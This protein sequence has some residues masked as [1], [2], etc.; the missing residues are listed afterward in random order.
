MRTIRLGRTGL[1]VTGLS[2]GSLPIQRLTME[3]A[4]RLLHRAYDEGINFYD[5][6][7]GYSD[8]EEKLGRAFCSVRKN[9]ILATKSHAKNGEALIKEIETS[10]KMLKTDYIDVMQLHNPGAVPVP[11]DGSGLYEAALDARR[12]GKIRFI[13]ISNHKLGNARDAIASGLYDTLQYPFS[14]L[15]VQNELELAGLCQEA[16]MGF[17]AMKALCGGLLRDIPAAYAFIR[18]YPNVVPIW[19]IQKMEEL[20]EF[21]ALEKNPPAWDEHMEVAMAQEKASLGKEF[22]RGCGYCLPC[23][24]EIPIPTLARMIL[25]LNRSPWRKHTTADAQE[26]M[27]RADNCIHCGACAHRC[28]YE[29]DP[30]QL[31]ADNYR[32]YKLFLDEKKASGAI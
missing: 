31:V 24:A 8:S 23:P 21:L 22:C 6:A 15:S 16:D 19:G 10:L 13:G 29:L 9:I 5:T 30:E 27:S 2:F 28:P 12:A 14:I 11:G 25:F 26:K 4:E 3:E 1:E 18:C 17:I 20:E 32:A 7:R